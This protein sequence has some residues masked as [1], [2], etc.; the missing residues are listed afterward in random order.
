MNAEAQTDPIL[1]LADAIESRRGA[2][3]ATDPSLDRAP[4]GA[5]PLVYQLIYSMLLWEGS[6][7]LAARCLEAIR[8]EVVDFNELRVCS[9]EEVC[10]LLP[11]DCPR[12]PE[13]VDRLLT[14]LNDIFLREH[15]LT[16]AHL[17]ALPKREARQYLDA[18]PG[19]PQ[20]VAARVMLV[21]LGGHAFPTDSRIGRVLANAG[22]ID[23]ADMDHPDLGTR[24][25]RSVRAADSARVYALLEAEAR[26]LPPPKG[27]AR[28]P[29]ARSA[30]PTPPAPPV[31]PPETPTQAH[32]QSPQS[33]ENGDGKDA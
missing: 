21:S 15:G 25:E 23:A 16:L 20:F 1:A 6:H 3:P 10:A 30:R 18:L 13:R 31:H 9:V 29:A 7:D 26:D 33:G 32:P 24:L 19:L 17:N 14:A 27:G 8:A 5:D 11:R 12:R 22:V 2:P 28:K 4:L